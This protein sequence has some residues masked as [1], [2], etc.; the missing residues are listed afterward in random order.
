M[1]FITF[2]TLSILIHVAVQ[3]NHVEAWTSL[4]STT[5]I[6]TSR[7]ARTV[8]KRPSSPILLSDTCLSAVK[9]K[10]FDEMLQVYHDKSI[11]V[12]FY[13]KW[14][15][16][17]KLIKKE[18]QLAEDEL[19]EN[20]EEEIIVMN[21]NTEKFPS[22][23]SRFKIDSLPTVILFQ[24]QAEVDRLVGPVVAQDI[25]TRFRPFLKNS[26]NTHDNVAASVVQEK[27]REVRRIATVKIKE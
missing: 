21:V 19:R 22:L 10:N 27:E 3:N 4:P 2:H 23:A 9:F 20:G 17:C 16:P 14:C 5:T 8:R 25:L 15:G 11:L 13:A 6:I 18:I 12:D 24:N 7:R 26:K 1:L